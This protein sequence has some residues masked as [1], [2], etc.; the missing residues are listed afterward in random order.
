VTAEPPRLTTGRASTILAQVFDEFGNPVANVPVIFRITSGPAFARLDSGGRAVFTDNT[1]R[2]TD[3]LRT[4]STATGSVEVT[5]TVPGVATP[6]TV[7]V[8]INPVS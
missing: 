5:A 2:A 4:N 8:P 3:T 7:T 1:G 6:G